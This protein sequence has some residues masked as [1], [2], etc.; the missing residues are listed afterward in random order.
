MKR[1]L[2]LWK[3]RAITVNT[4]QEACGAGC[5][6]KLKVRENKSTGKKTTAYA[7]F[8]GT[9]WKDDTNRFLKST[10]TLSAKEMDKVTD[11]AKV[12]TKK[13]MKTE[14]RASVMP[15]DNNDD[16][17]NVILCNG[18]ESSES[19]HEDGADA[20]PVLQWRNRCKFSHFLSH[21]MSNIAFKLLKQRDQ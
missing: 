3:D 9:H 21:Y 11:L 16:D 17:N 5:S 6:I 19:T 4:V 1:A 2:L 8:S 13:V 7:A 10:M 20:V 12:A 18:S 14:E 15:I